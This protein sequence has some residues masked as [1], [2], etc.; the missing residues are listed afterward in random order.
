PPLNN[1]EMSYDGRTWPKLGKKM[2]GLRPLAQ[3]FVASDDSVLGPFSDPAGR[4]LAPPVTYLPMI[5]AAFQPEYWSSDQPVN[6][7]GIDS[8]KTASA[9]I[10]NTNE[11]TQAE[12]NFALF[13][14][15]AIQAYEA[16]LVSDD[17]PFD[18]FSEGIGGTLS[19]EQQNGLNI[20]LRAE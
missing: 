11:F 3:Q 12:F 16:T 18:R 15:L 1:I 8:A 14:G 2:L 10:N 19:T 5:Q 20:F 6:R 9:S 13:W 17:S 7:M 4:G